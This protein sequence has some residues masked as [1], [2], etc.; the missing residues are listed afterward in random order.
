MTTTTRATLPKL[1]QH[2]MYRPV[3]VY[4]IYICIYIYTYL[5]LYIC[6]HYLNINIL[7]LYVH[8]YIDYIQCILKLYTMNEDAIM[9][10]N[11]HRAWYSVDNIYIYIHTIPKYSRLDL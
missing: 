3:H 6:I 8:I 11:E 4:Y 9:H 1:I 7:I 5:R 10:S 2:A